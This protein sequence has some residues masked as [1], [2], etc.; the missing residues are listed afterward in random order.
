MNT[1]LSTCIICDG[2]LVKSVKSN[3]YQYFTCTSCYSSHLIPFPSKTEL[4][5]LKTNVRQLCNA[6]S[7]DETFKKDFE[8]DFEHGN[9]IPNTKSSV[10]DIFEFL[11]RNL[12]QPVS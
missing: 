10:K 6:Q 8:G 9:G 3:Y 2:N 12:H 7:D 4:E 11:K 1:I 5:N